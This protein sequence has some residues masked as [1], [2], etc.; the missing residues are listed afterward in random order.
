MNSLLH[1]KLKLNNI[2]FAGDD[3]DNSKNLRKP[4]ESCT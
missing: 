2:L 1:R 4:S 3:D